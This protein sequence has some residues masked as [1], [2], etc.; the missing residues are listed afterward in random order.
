MIFEIFWPKIVF[1]AFLEILTKFGSKWLL[2]HFLRLV[3]IYVYHS[4]IPSGNSGVANSILKN[5]AILGRAD[6]VIIKKF[7]NN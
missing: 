1:L 5:L 6:T 3:F 4:N 7:G 2:H